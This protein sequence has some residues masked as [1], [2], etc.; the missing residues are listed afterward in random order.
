MLTKDQITNSAA[1]VGLDYATVA[2][3][4]A[5]ETSGSGMS[6]ETNFPT[7]LFEGHIFSRLTNHVYDSTNPTISYP[8]WTRQF[9]GKNQ[10]Q[11][12][13][14]LQSA[15][16][17]NRDTALQ[18]ASYDL[19]QIMGF[20]YADCG[21]SSVQDFVNKMCA[22]EASQLDLFLTFISKKGYVS[23]LKNKDWANFARV[24]NGPDFKLNNYDTKLAAAYNRFL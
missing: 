21:C 9:Y 3:V 5:V 11:E 12:N 19:F 22:G 2:A 20:N 14:R 6:T 18:S 17:L 1:K 16:K 8:K 15:V 4:A 7:I 13:A 23:Y 24:Y 10:T